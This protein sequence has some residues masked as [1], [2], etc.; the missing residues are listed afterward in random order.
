[1]YRNDTI[2]SKQ[3]YMF[4][5][6]YYMEHFSNLLFRSKILFR[7]LGNYFIRLIN[8]YSVLHTIKVLRRSFKFQN[9]NHEKKLTFGI[10]TKIFF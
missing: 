5:F 10:Q 3:I 8:E 1:M 2:F 4:I 9:K 6:I 7:S